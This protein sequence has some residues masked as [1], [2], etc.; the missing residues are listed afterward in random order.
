MFAEKI[1]QILKEKSL[2]NHPFYRLWQQGRLTRQALQGYAAEYYHLESSFPSFLLSASMHADDDQTD[3]IMKNYNEETTGKSH[4]DLWLDFTKALEMA[5]AAVRK[6]APMESTS[7][8]LNR[9]K[10]LTGTGLFPAVGALLAYEA[11]LQ[12]TAATKIN[13]LQQF[14]NISDEKSTAFFSIHGTLDIKHSKDWKDMLVASAQS[15]D[16]QQAVLDAVMESMDLLWG[17]LDGIHEK[18]CAGMSC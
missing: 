5:P 7:A 6:T 3:I 16:E 18:Y 15:A 8:L 4:V 11:N 2:L 17:F 1:N 9:F 12:E 10:T 14:Y 13:G